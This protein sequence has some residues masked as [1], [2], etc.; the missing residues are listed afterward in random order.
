MPRPLVLP[1]PSTTTL[2][3]APLQLVACQVRHDRNLAVAD[4][5]RVLAIREQLANYSLME[6]IA[7]QAVGIVLGPSGPASV[8][9]GSDQRG[10]RLRSD[11]GAWTVALLPD[12]FALECTGYTSWTVFSER[13][14]ALADAVLGHLRPT[15]ELRLGLRY[16]DRIGVPPAERPQD[17][18]G[19]INEHL[20][21]A[22]LD[23]QLGSA[24]ESMEQ[25][26]QLQGP[27]G[28]QVILRHGTQ[29]D[30]QSGTWPYL[31]DTDCFRSDGRKL[32]ADSLSSGVDELHKIALQVFQASITQSLH[33][34][35]S[36]R[37]D[38]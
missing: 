14:L 20:L 24:L 2:A 21:G 7:Q 6:E 27:G 22:L 13:M 19:Y 28:I 18:S 16:V 4:G 1:D 9:R 8:S 31:L 10:W 26:M 3:Q 23:E 32:E 17:W 33:D 34:L 35:L 11:D 30:S 36:G 25:V 38:P 12:F 37:E 5:N 29:L 15:V